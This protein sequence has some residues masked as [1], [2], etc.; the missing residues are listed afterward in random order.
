MDKKTK[1]RNLHLAAEKELKRKLVFSDGDPDS[2]IVFIG[3]APGRH[4]EE[5]GKPFVGNSGKLL[6][7]TLEKNGIDRKDVYITNIVL[8]RPPNNR[9]P[10]KKE[11]ESCRRFLIKHIRIIKPR[12]ICTL[13][14]TSLEFFAKGKRITA[15]RGKPIK[16]TL[17]KI[18]LHILPTFHPAAILYNRK[19]QKLF[20][21]DIRKLKKYA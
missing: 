20:E 21:A 7:K 5:Q 3:E 17:D 14:N 19:L 1:L 6:N 9:K 16:I 2:G 10:T 15:V 11:V 4:E 13:G 12:I 8:W 18:N